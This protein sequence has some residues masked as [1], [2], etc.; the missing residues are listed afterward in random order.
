MK[1]LLASSAIPVLALASLGCATMED[2]V[3][4]R[5]SND[6]KCP[7]ER[8]TVN[9]IGGTSYRATG[10]RQEATYNCTQSTLQGAVTC[11]R[12]EQKSTE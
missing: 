5:A 12:E 10:C 11:V 4:T 2:T 3:Q 6:L 1:T 8:I 9:N 7:E